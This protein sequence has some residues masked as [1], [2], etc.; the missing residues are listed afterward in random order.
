MPRTKCA[1][2]GGKTWRRERGTP[3]VAT[4]ASPIRSSA[5]AGGS[6]PRP[7][8]RLSPGV[9]TGRSLGTP[10]TCGGWP[11]FSRLILFDKRGTGLSDRAAGIASL[12]ERMD[13]VRAVMDAAGSERAVLFGVSES[14]PLHVPLRRHLS[15]ADS[16]PDPLWRLRLGGARTRLPLAANRRGVRGG[17][18]RRRAGRSTRTGAPRASATAGVSTPS[19]PT[20]R[21]VSRAN[22][23]FAPGSAPSC[24]WP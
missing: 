7:R 16:G 12:E 22:P 3:A 1:T 23:R 10:A 19:S 4:S 14:A 2:Q 20:W 5:T 18:R 6:G 15:G 11:S 17:P 13:D 24:G 9:R 21:R 8:L